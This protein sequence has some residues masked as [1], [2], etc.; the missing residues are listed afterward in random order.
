MARF[1]LWLGRH[2]GRFLVERW[3]A[4]AMWLWCP[5]CERCFREVQQRT[6]AQGASLCPYRNCSGSWSSAWSWYKV[7]QLKQTFPYT[8]EPN[9]R[10]HLQKR[11]R[12]G[13]HHT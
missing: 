8:P 6:D 2:A 10:Y 3:R 13:W 9:R 7:I 11:R 12:L 1:L 4:K 5:V